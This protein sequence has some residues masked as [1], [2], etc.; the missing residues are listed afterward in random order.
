LVGIVATVIGQ[1]EH[2]FTGAIVAAQLRCEGFMCPQ[3]TLSISRYDTVRYLQ[4]DFEYFLQEALPL[5][6]TAQRSFDTHTAYDPVARKFTLI[7]ADH[8]VG[9]VDSIW[10]S[11]IGDA[12]NL[13]TPITTNLMIA[14]PDTAPNNPG[15]MK[16]A[17]ILSGPEG[18]TIAMYTDGSIHELD[19]K[20]K[21]YS[22]LGSLFEK[23]PFAS[24][25]TMTDAHVVDGNV[26]KSFVK[27]GDLNV[28]MIKTTISASGISVSEPLFIKSIRSINIKVETPI[29]AHMVSTHD[30]EEPRLLLLLASMQDDVGFDSFFFVDESS[31]QLESVV[32]NLMQGNTPSLLTCFVS[33]KECD[34]WRTSAYDA[35]KHI[36]YFQAHTIDAAGIETVAIM[37]LEWSLNHITGKYIPLVN[38]VQWPMNFGYSGYQY[39]TM[40]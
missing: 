5:A 26:I 9:G 1:K 27:D 2:D 28:Y 30:G 7:A 32:D 33:L 38:V 3:W 17:R 37:K 35:D 24:T 16:L 4:T 13:T 39:V 20:G 36:V 11:T 19:I 8:P 6:P 18:R 34:Y 22:K 15:S 29:A 21:Q 25:A 31:G 23:A 14:H 12:V 40:K 10:E